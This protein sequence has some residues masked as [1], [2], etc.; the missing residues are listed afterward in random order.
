MTK[1]N[2]YIAYTGGTIGMQ[3]SDMGYVPAPGSLTQQMQTMQALQHDDMPDFTVHE[4]EPIIDSADMSPANW[5]Q[6]AD[7]IAEHYDDYDGFIVLHGTDTMAYSAS[8]LSFMLENLAKPVVFT[9]SQVPLIEAHTDARENLIGALLFA[10]K[11]ELHEVCV[12]FDNKLYRGNRCQKTNANSYH[13]FDSVN[14]PAIGEVAL[15][16]NLRDDCQFSKV[17]KPLSVQAIKNTQLAHIRLFPGL[18]SR[19]LNNILDQPIQALVM[20]TYGIGNAPVVNQSLVDI[21]TA[22]TNRGVVIVNTSQCAIANVNMDSYPTGR[23]LKDIG[24]ISGFDMTAESAITKL[25]YLFSK[26]DNIETIKTQM[27][28]N[29]RGEL[30]P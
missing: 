18:D 28:T 9:G 29:L 5:Q 11:P 3:R 24:I 8:A 13:A 1:P 7:D 14:Y 4:Y 10:C 20:E 2:I 21:L 6:I 17:S 23:A 27:Q 15:A 25:H 26:Y 22:A 30:T 19:V 12:F 16:L